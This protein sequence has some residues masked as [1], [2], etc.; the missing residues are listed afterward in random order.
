MKSRSGGD[1]SMSALPPKAAAAVADRR[2][3]FGPKGDQAQCNKNAT[4]SI[5]S[6]ARA[7]S[8]AETL[9]PSARAVLRFTT[10]SYLTGC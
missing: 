6:S 8:E 10:N 5:T 4:Y 7:R 9:R 1:W 2:V 3:H